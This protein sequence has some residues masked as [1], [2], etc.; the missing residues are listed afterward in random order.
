MRVEPYLHRAVVELQRGG[1]KVQPYALTALG[2]AAQVPGLVRQHAWEPLMDAR[3]TYVDPPISKIMETVEEA[4][5]EAK[6]A[7]TSKFMAHAR[8][9]AGEQQVFEGAPTSEESYVH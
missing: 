8:E 5:G 1:R 3:R 9:T 7:T 6:A 4:G 2:Y